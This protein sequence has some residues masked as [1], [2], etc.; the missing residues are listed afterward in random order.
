[1]S[2]GC[3][4]ADGAGRRAG[5][6]VSRLRPLNR[7]E[8]WHQETPLALDGGRREGVPR[9]G[10][11]GARNHRGCRATCKRMFFC[12][13]RDVHE[14]SLRALML[15]ELPAT[16]RRAARGLKDKPMT[17]E[18]TTPSVTSRSDLMGSAHSSRGVNRA[19]GSGSSLPTIG[20]RIRHTRRRPPRV[21]RRRWAAPPV[22]RGWRTRPAGPQPQNAARNRWAP[23]GRVPGLGLPATRL[24]RP[25]PTGCRSS[26]RSRSGH[27]RASTCTDAGHARCERPY[28][29]TSVPS[30]RSTRPDGRSAPQPEARV[31]ATG[32]E[33]CYG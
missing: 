3:R 28:C 32:H 27:T 22:G 18:L 24:G 5:R 1:M 16:V 14:G 33:P 13:E 11:P 15:P 2:G 4:C 12:A 31:S 9:T 17:V 20:R 19:S 25:R 23:R 7:G 6:P 21:R 8:P 30:C 26:C 10:S 29:A